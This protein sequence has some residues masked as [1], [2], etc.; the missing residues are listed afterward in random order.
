MTK[1]I[2]SRVAYPIGVFVIAVPEAIGYLYQSS[3]K[4]GRNF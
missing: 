1:I 2:P 3:Y 4:A